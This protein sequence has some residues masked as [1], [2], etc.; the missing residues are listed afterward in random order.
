MNTRQDFEAWYS[1]GGQAPRSIEKND[2]GN[3]LLSNTYLAWMTWQAATARQEA[4]IK[5]LVDAAELVLAWYEAEDDHAK[6]PDFYKRIAMCRASEDALR[7]ALAAA[8]ETS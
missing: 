5:A 6:E 4:K 3:Y 2:L 7:A 8:K 1:D